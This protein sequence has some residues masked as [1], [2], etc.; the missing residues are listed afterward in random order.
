MREVIQLHLNTI[1]EL[2][3]KLEI[4]EAALEDERKCSRH[5]LQIAE[6]ATRNQVAMAH[7]QAAMARNLEVLTTP[8]SKKVG[9]LLLQ[10]SQN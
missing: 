3:R 1:R 10:I 2:R 6:N 7:N 8:I 9:N 5:L 4:T